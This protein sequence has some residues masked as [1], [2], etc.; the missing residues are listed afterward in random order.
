MPVETLF[1][2]VTGQEAIRLSGGSTFAVTECR[3]SNQVYNL[4][5]KFRDVIIPGR[6]RMALY[7][8]VEIGDV[9]LVKELM[10]LWAQT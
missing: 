3:D 5:P 10:D 4:V 8:A 6:G 1:K 2:L 9:R 7:F